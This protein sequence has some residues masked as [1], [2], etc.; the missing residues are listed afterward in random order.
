M[1]ACLNLPELCQNLAIDIDW[2][3]FVILA[4]SDNIYPILTYCGKVLTDLSSSSLVTTF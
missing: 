2:F 3:F 1:E 4:E